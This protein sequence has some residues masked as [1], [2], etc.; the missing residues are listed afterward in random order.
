MGTG[1]PLDNYD[2]LCSFIRMLSDENGLNISQRNITVSSCG[3]VPEIKRLADEHFS[4]TFALSLHAATDEKEESLMP[5][6]KKYS[7]AEKFLM[8]ADIILMRPEEGLPLNIRL[9]QEKMI[10]KMM[11]KVIGA[12]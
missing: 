12:Y 2:N 7:L 11:Q 6:A 10:P 1:E 5:I 3:L 4:I 9:L 8:P